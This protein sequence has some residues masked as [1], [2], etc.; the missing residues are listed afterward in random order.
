MK[1]IRFISTTVTGGH[2]RILALVPALILGLPAFGETYLYQDDF[3]TDAV[4]RDSWRHS[5]V[6]YTPPPV[7]LGGVLVYGSG[8]F[9]RGL[10]FSPG[11]DPGMDAYLDYAIVPPQGVTTAASVSFL[12]L[13]GG[14]INIWGSTNGSTWL[15]LG[16]VSLPPGLGWQFVSMPLSA[17]SPAQYLSLQGRGTI[18]DLQISVTYYVPRVPVITQAQLTGAGFILRGSNGTPYQQYVVLNTTNVAL[19]QTHWTHVATNTFG[20]TGYF[21]CTNVVAPTVRQGYLRLL[22]TAP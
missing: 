13:A 22:I 2:F 12:L 7:H 5:P 14:Y 20:P 19:P 11:F 6:Y 1:I 9:G 17:G 8:A 10:G 18:D 21:D 16:A 3:E 15:P 4:V